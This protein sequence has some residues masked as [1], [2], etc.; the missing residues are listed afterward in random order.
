MPP[1]HLPPN[2]CICDCVRLPPCAVTVSV[3][4]AIRPILSAPIAVTTR[5]LLL[6]VAVLYAGDTQAALRDRLAAPRAALT[7]IIVGLRR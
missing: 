7:S 1:S 2:R 3:K 5:P 6:R 4:S